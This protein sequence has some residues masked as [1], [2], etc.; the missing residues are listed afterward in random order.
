VGSKW[1]AKSPTEFSFVGTSSGW[2]RDLLEWLCPPGP[3]WLV[4]HFPNLLANIPA[5]TMSTTAHL[6]VVG[7]Y[8]PEFGF[9]EVVRQM[10]FPLWTAL[11]WIGMPLCAA[12]PGTVQQAVQRFEAMCSKVPA[13]LGSQFRTTAAKVLEARHPELAQ[14]LMPAGPAAGKFPPAPREEPASHLPKQPYISS[15]DASVKPLRM[16]IGLSSSSIWRPRCVR[17]LLAPQSSTWPGICAARFPKGIWGR[18]R[19][20]L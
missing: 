5:D 13:P 10:R 12:G 8:V 7:L 19:L 20:R 16:L 1:R 4:H 18:R 9:V 6:S 14:K 15:S 2:D 17:C 11:V 3:L